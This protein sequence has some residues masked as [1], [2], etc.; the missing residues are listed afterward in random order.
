MSLNNRLLVGSVIGIA[1]LLLVYNR[2]VAKME[3][4]VWCK[5]CDNGSYAVQLHWWPV[6][7]SAVVSLLVFVVFTTVNR[8]IY[9]KRKKQQ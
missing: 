7:Q 5:D 6:L 9:D 4:V 1:T 2:L 8:I 3:N